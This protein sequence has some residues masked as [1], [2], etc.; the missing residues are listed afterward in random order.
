MP[1]SEWT[2]HETVGPTPEVPP[3]PIKT[4]AT[5]KPLARIAAAL[6]TVLGVLVTIPSLAGAMTITFD[7]S[8]FVNGQVITGVPGVTIQADNQVLPYN[9]AVIFDSEQSGSLYPQLEALQTG[10]PRWS[11]GNLEGVQLDNMLV[12]QGCK[13]QKCVDTIGNDRQP[14]GTI[15]FT[16]DVPI[17]SIGFDLINADMLFAKYG[18]VTFTDVQGLS[19]TIEDKTLLAGY[20]IGDNTANRIAPFTAL[21]LGLDSIKTVTFQMGG[22]GALD[23]ITFV[24]IP[25]PATA[26]F[27]GLG[28]ALLGASRRNAR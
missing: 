11:G 9:Q 15:R 24:P 18:S 3:M 8:G 5:S 27:L 23:N 2:G 16:F 10:L 7:D 21:A 14:T 13:D 28:L 20:Q 4:V 25:E 6:A 22:A 1:E 12:L 19:V 17:T 26:L